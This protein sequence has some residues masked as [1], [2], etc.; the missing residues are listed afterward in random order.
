MRELANASSRVLRNLG[1]D[2]I[3]LIIIALGILIKDLIATHQDV[4]AY[5]AATARQIGPGIDSGCGIYQF[6]PSN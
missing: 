2:R 6:E 4:V 1:Q 3:A 5:L